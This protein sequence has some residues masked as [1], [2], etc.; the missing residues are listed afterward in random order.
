MVRFDGQGVEICLGCGGPIGGC[1]GRVGTGFR[2]TWEGGTGVS[3]LG[4]VRNLG[5]DPRG[6]GEERR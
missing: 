2:G 4:G 5:E 3:A 6:R 1:A